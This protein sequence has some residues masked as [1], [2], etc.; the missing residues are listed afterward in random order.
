MVRLPAGRQAQC[1]A[2]K[3]FSHFRVLA[4]MA[5]RLIGGVL[6]P[7]KPGLQALK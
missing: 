3:A 4:S 5:Y 7:L 2:N 1:G 6:F